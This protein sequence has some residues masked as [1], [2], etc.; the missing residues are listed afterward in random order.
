[1]IVRSIR[2]LVN[3]EEGQ[4][5]IEYALISGVVGVAGVLL[6]PVIRAKMGAAYTSWKT[7]AQTAWE[8]CPPIA[9]GGCP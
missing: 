3:D 9:S 7:G 6:F 5:L 1:M 4:D 8:P 2:R